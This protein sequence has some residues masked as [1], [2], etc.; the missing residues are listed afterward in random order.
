MCIL[1]GHVTSDKGAPVADALIAAIPAGGDRPADVARSDAQGRYCFGALN[2]GSYGFT[3]T[4]PDLTSAYS[5]VADVS[6]AGLNLMSLP[7][8]VGGPG[9]TLSGIVRDDKGAPVPG[10]RVQISRVSNYLADLFITDTGP[11][12]RYRVKLPEA[13]YSP[14]IRTEIQAANGEMVHLTKDAT[15]DLQVQ[16]LN[17]EGKPAPEEVVAWVKSRAIP[18]VSAEAGRGLDDMAPLGAVVGDA[19]VVA[20]GEATHG[21]REFFQL[22]H[23]M[24]EYLVEKKGFRSFGIEAS[25][26]D[27][28]P[29]HEYVRTGK[30]D[31]AAALAN[32]GFWTWDTE[33]VLSL[34]KW[35]RAYNEDKSHKEKLSFWGYDMQSPAASTLWLLDYFGKVDPSFAK[36]MGPALEPVDESFTLQFAGPSVGPELG[37]C[38]EMAR[39]ILQKLGSNEKEYAK[40]TNPR[41][42]ALARI[43]AQ[44]LVDS[45]SMHRGDGAVRDRSMADIAAALLAVEEMDAKA[46]KGSPG[47]AAKMVLWAHNGHVSKHDNA[48]FPSLG[49]HLSKRFGKDYM[50]FGFAFDEGSFQAVDASKEHRGL[51]PF[52]VPEAPPG[53]LDHTLARAGVPLLALDL[54]GAP[55]GPVSDWL[56]RASLSRSIGALFDP[57]HVDAYSDWMSPREHF[58]ALLFVQKTS[59]ARANKTGQ[60]SPSKDDKP[61]AE[62]VPDP[63]FESAR[64]GD[65]PT[66]WSTTAYPRQLELRVAVSD[67]KC[68]AGKHCLSLERTKGDVATGVG[69]AAF[70]L[71]ALPYRGS[72]IRVTAKARVDGR[73]PGDEAFLLVI[74]SDDQ[75]RF[76]K[77]PGSSWKD[78]E[79]LLDVPKDAKSLRIGLSVTGAAKAGLDDVEVHVVPVAP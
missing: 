1:A 71:D 70:S 22:K 46:D 38:Q 75:V 26:G 40:K 30:G 67:K 10:V 61:P 17:P 74:G 21:T 39:T 49:F 79:V 33:E 18:L 47:R 53:S 63:G 7:F 78:V 28:L 24:L 62:R 16:S 59:A 19:R 44:V 43:H 55:A 29:L 42:L 4:T 77:I 5:D 23:R 20:L 9:H 34:V 56:A 76:A 15:A 35:M 64:V 65:T 58:D 66:G 73:G 69:S 51:V 13:V 41:D 60:R 32:Q 31:P 45:L 2:V 25:F 14:R 12:G 8:V 37:P 36:E 52:T 72:K 57:S 6:P 3:I 50:V 54:R 68:A 48:G 11:D 27:C